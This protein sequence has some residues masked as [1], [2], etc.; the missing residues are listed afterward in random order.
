MRIWFAWYPV[1]SE[2]GEFLWLTHVEC[3]LQWFSDGYMDTYSRYVYRRV[4]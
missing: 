2:S 1:W 3:E 4:A